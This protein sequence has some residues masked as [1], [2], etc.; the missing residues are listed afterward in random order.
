MEATIQDFRQRSSPRRGDARGSFPSRHQRTGW[1]KVSGYDWQ[2]DPR[3]SRN[4]L[5][6]H[7][8]RRHRRF[9]STFGRS[10]WAITPGRCVGDLAFINRVDGGDEVVDFPQARRRSKIGFQESTS[11]A[12]IIRGEGAAPRS[13][14]SV[15][16][17]QLTNAGAM[18]DPRL[19]R[20]RTLRPN[21]PRAQ[22]AHPRELRRPLRLQ[23]ASDAREARIRLREQ[24]AATYAAARRAID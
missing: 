12:T 15:R 4:I 14:R 24:P 19:L 11:F 1:L 5:R 3:F 23:R 10:N 20:Q 7:A 13:R 21:G 16:S 6:V 9:A 17:M 18:Q 22:S 2:D 8:H